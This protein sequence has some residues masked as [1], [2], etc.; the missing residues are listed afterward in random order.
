MFNFKLFKT[1]KLISALIDQME[2]HFGFFGFGH[3]LHHLFIKK[4]YQIKL[5]LLQIFYTNL[6]EF[7]EYGRNCVH[8]IL[9]CTLICMQLELVKPF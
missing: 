9:E 4:F 3:T 1:K 7:N 8:K 6:D 2:K 5:K